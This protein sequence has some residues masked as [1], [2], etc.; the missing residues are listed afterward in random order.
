MPVVLS[1][2]VGTTTITA[3]AVDAGNGAI[4]ASA[5]TA[6]GAETTTAAGKARGHSEWDAHRMAE[7]ACACLGQVAEQLGGRAREAAGLGLTGQQHGVVV[8]NEALTPLTPFFGW[9][10]R[11]G[12]EIDPATGTSL[13][14]RARELVGAEAPQRAG[15][16]LATG[17]LAVTLFALKQAGTLPPAGTACFITDYVAALLTGRPPVT[18]ATSAASSGIFN[19]AGGDWDADL[20]AA[21]GLPGVMLPPVRPAGAHLGDLVPGLVPGLPAGLPVFLGIG[22]NQASFLGSVADR[23]STVLVNV[24]TGGQVAAFTGSYH[25][26][27]LLETRPFPGGGYLLVSAGLCGGRSYALLEGFFRAVGA[28][29]LGV[30]PAGPLYGIMNELA[31]AVPSGADGLRCE[32]LFTGTRHQP[33][34]RASWSGVSAENFT[35]AH[36]TRALLEGLARVFRESYEYVAA[37]GGP[38]RLLVGAGNGLRENPVL[39]RVVAEGMALPLQVPLHREEAAYGAALLAAVGAGIFANLE[40]AGRLIHYGKTSSAPDKKA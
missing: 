12:D 29:F 40:A 37:I 1:L 3:L 39:A 33:E 22:D 38:R 31:A 10:D 25:Y 15:C 8:V 14:Q 34:L 13:V 5:T 32:P 7:S 9:Q 35:P 18:D 21:L 2:D 30:Q 4:L 36:M 24:G 26:D 19:V 27:S 28:Q 16:Q 23:T 11:R 6:N 20:A 17:Y